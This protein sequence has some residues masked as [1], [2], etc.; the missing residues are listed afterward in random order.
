MF[1]PDR[2]RN[3]ENTGVLAAFAIP[4][5]GVARGRFAAY[6]RR[7]MADGNVSFH[8]RIYLKNRPGNPVEVELL[9][10]GLK[11]DLA[12]SGEGLGITNNYQTA[13]GGVFVVRLDE[14]AALQAE[15]VNA[16]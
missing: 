15:V 1:I 8:Y 5:R 12:A 7:I 11:D 16:G 10:E 13:S 2:A 4:A 3:R 9:S 6:A 14:I